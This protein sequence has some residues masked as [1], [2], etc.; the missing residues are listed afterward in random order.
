MLVH[1]HLPNIHCGKTFY[2]ENISQHPYWDRCFYACAGQTLAT[3]K[4]RGNILAAWFIA[5]RHR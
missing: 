3:S 5:N 2:L 4:K 1:P